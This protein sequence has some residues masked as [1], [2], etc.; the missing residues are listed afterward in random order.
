[1][2]H[3]YNKAEKGNVPQ[4]TWGK[5]ATASYSLLP[6][7]HTF[8]RFTLRSLFLS[9]IQRAIFITA[10]EMSL[11]HGAWEFTTLKHAFPASWC[12]QR[13]LCSNAS[14]TSSA[15]AHAHGRVQQPWRESGRRA[16]AA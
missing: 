15:L 10:Q 11:N 12:L 5:K 14:S 4:A 8:L 9:H 2:D 13:T 16:E 7:C 6:N 1:M 3:G